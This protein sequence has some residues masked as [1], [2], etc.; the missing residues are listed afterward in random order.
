MIEALAGAVAGAGLTALGLGVFHPKV[1]LFGPE[2]SHGP[3]DVRQVALSFDDG[4]HPDFTPRIAELLAAAE[5]KAT[6]FCIGAFAEKHS[7][8]ARALISAGHE[9]GNHTFSH[10]TFRHLFSAPALTEDL[11][12]C[13]RLLTSFGAAPRWYRPA[14]G[15]R[16][17]PVHAAARALGLQIV[18]WS[19]AARDGAIAFDEARARRLAA[20]SQ[21]GDVLVLH[22]GVRGAQSEL[23][24]ATVRWLPALLEG[25]KERGLQP[26]TV[27][28]VMNQ[29]PPAVPARNT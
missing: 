29:F 13:Q 18:T 20:R 11:Y 8:V 3:R 9:L 14:V 15:I 22:D 2:H 1:A 12:R 21:P 28:Q 27:S 16:N 23:R 24:K 7:E 25:L 5:A 19:H 26:V 10:D 17:P 6:F 4:P